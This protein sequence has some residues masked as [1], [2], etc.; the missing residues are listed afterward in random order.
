[1][2][3]KILTYK[4]LDNESKFI[5]NVWETTGNND[6]LEEYEGTLRD[7]VSHLS[8]SEIQD[9]DI[10][11]TV[12]IQ[13]AECDLSIILSF[14]D[15]EYNF[16][17]A[18]LSGGKIIYDLNVLLAYVLGSNDNRFEEAMYRALG[19]MISQ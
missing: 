5:Y 11:E 2:K 6:N 10:V 3:M 14:D 18:E 19:T 9:L 15:G 4:E 7:L 13:T 16:V 1:M 17:R 12:T 8:S